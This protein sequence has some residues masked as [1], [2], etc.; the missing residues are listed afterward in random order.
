LKWWVSGKTQADFGVE[1]ESVV[2]SAARYNTANKVAMEEI[3]WAPDMVDNL[4]LQA[5]IL[6]PYR[7]V[8]GGYFT[9]R[10]FDFAFRKIVYDK[11]D[12]RECMNQTIFD[13]NKELT[14]KRKEYNL[15]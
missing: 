4:M 11:D 12:V 3:K 13:I 6:E 7:E 10:L 15:D 5:E 1:L 8:P 2:G 9:T 14:N